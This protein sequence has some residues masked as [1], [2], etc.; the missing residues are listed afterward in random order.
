MKRLFLT[1]LSIVAISLSVSTS[2]QARGRTEPIATPTTQLSY[3]IPTPKYVT[4][5]ELVGSAYQGQYRA[6]SIPGF[7]SLID[8]ARTGKITAKDLVKAAIESGSL[9]PEMINDR[10]YLSNVEFQ[11]KGFRF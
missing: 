6:H 9:L 8:G 1:S 10:D 4:P 2:A 7:S 3:N 5:F 11:L